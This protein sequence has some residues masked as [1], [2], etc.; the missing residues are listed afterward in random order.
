MAGPFIYET[1]P[2]LPPPVVTVAIVGGVAVTSVG[3]GLADPKCLPFVPEELA[4]Q[5][6]AGM[7]AQAAK[8]TQ[9]AGSSFG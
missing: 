4:E 1:A 9:Q 2:V 8:I 3:S 6:A 7:Q 5:S